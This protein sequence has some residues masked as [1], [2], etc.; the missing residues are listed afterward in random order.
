MAILTNIQA[1]NVVFYL[2]GVVTDP[3]DV[4]IKISD[5]LRIVPINGA[6]FKG[7]AYPDAPHLRN[8][9]ALTFTV[10]ASRDN[11]N[12]TYYGQ[13]VDTLIAIAELPKHTVPFT[14]TN[15]GVYVN[16][17]LQQDNPV[18]LSVGQQVELRAIDGFYFASK[19]YARSAAEP[20]TVELELNEERTV[21]T[22]KFDKNV[23]TGLFADAVE[24]PNDGVK[25]IN[26]IYSMT[27]ELL[28]EFNNERFNYAPDAT[29]AT[30]N[31]AQFIINLLY[32]PY[33]INTDYI[34]PE[35]YI[36]LGDRHMRISAPEVN[37][38]VIRLDFGTIA[39]QNENS[40]ALDYVNTKIRLHLPMVGIM[41]LEPTEVIGK[42]ISAYCDIS[43]YDGATTVNV[44]N[45]N[46]DVIYQ[47]DKRLGVNI[48][49]A[50]Y[51]DNIKLTTGTISEST[52]YPI[53]N[54]YV[55][56]LRNVPM[57]VT[58]EM[59]TPITATETIGDLD[60]FVIVE[61]IRLQG[62]MNNQANE[63]IKRLLSNGVFINER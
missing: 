59:D 38:D 57:N 21:A 61:Q 15:T 31:Y 47:L 52:Y 11:A 17:V 25:G 55:E 32:L 16:D 27:R 35:D 37:S 24:L 43:V 46:D 5:V 18:E 40:N 54:A 36:Q 41:E 12:M 8:G 3:Q 6:K 1:E 4:E 2:N 53:R 62:I 23:Y 10:N 60:G 19:P 50:S 44:V 29:G 9:T 56:V 39:V 26:Y 28:G 45:E 34:E 51:L 30:K 22:F 49:L 33:E 14:V 20:Y 42:T 13:N 7:R 63:E 48:P 58:G